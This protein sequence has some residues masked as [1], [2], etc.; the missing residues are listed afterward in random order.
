MNVAVV[1]NQNS[2]DSL[3]LAN[4]Y[5]E[6]RQ[7]PPQ[8]VLRINWAGNLNAWTESDF[9][10]VL[11]NPLMTMLASRRLTNQIDY[12]VLSMAV[13]FEVSSSDSLAWNSTTSSLFYGFKPDPTPECSLA[14]GSASLYTGSEG[15]FRA[16]PPLNAAS[17]SFLATMITS[18][19]LAL[20]KAI[21]SQGVLSDG[22]FPTQTVFLTKNVYDPERN[23]RFVLYDNAIFNARLRGNLS[24]ERNLA[25]TPNGLGYTFGFQSGAQD[26]TLSGVTVAPG[27][28]ADN[29]TSYGGLINGTPEQFNML[30]FLSAGATATYGTVDEPCNY[31]EKFPNPMDY[32]YQARG[33]SLAE[34]YYQSVTNPYQGLIVGEPLAAPFASPPMGAWLGLPAKALLR[35]TTNLSLQITAT[36]THHPIA[37]VDLFVDG[38]FLTSLTNLPPQPGNLIN[39]TINGE[40]VSYTVPA[41]ASLNSIAN[42]LAATLNTA[43]HTNT[44]KI[45]ASAAGDRLELHSLDPFKPGAQVPLS[46]GS[47]RGAAPV[48]GTFIQASGTNFLDTAA[49]GLRGFTV[50]NAP[51]VGDYLQ[52]VVTKV[53]GVSITNAVTN[54]VNGATI[55]SF[56]YNLMGV[57]NADS[58]L[59]GADGAV[60]EDWFNGDRYLGV[61]LSQFNLRALSSG[62]E[63]S[64]IQTSLSGSPDLAITPSDRQPLNDQLADLQ[65]RAHLYLTQGTYA[66]PLTF[67]FDTTGLPDGFHE[68]TAVIY[69]GSNVRVQ[70]RA[71]Q[72]VQIQ[73]TLLAAVFSTPFSGSNLAV[74]ATVSFSVSANTNA[75]ASIELFSTG[76]SLGVLT[77]QSS[78]RFSVAGT[79]LEVGLHPFYALVTAAD[80]SRYR[81]ET[82][83]IRLVGTDSPF[84]VSVTHPPS[85]TLT[86]PATAGRT[87]DVLTTPQLGANF[88]FATSVTPTNGTGSWVETYPL[89]SNRWYRVRTHD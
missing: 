34:S 69:E 40:P 64:G 83:W 65:P 11:V 59:Q 82:K 33:F 51:L 1:V 42:A 8:N 71:A 21:V 36:D 84:P 67:A 10:S 74:E 70:R 55:S 28:I 89:S 68:L 24:L 39:V 85:L 19:N 20:A 47:T 17:N 12:V 72:T 18:S 62:W 73:N 49:Y 76:G 26:Y 16:T 23:V 30:G 14:P 46:A 75:I 80:G 43:A 56:V 13:P 6:M 25:S 48:L 3:R 50:T 32:F 78:A 7:I 2:P 41:N 81:T 45:T 22:V 35:G 61:S 77:A 29:L 66:L 58:R 57:I 88:Q 54:T 52:L 9:A 60:A 53:N 86:W 37:Q 15:V 44:M 87:Y 63:A 79:N 31:L 38:T 27:G 4:Y 5:C